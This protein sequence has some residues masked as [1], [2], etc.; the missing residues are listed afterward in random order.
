[1]VKKAGEIDF[2]IGGRL[3]LAR[4]TVYEECLSCGEKVL[5]PEVSQELFERIKN[6][7]YV[8]ETVKIPVLDGTYG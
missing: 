5:S 4:N 8:E 6:R 3:Y 2:R 1:M 7:E